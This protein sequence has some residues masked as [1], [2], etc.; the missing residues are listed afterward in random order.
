MTGWLKLNC[1]IQTDSVKIQNVKIDVYPDATIGCIK[2]YLLAEII[3][4]GHQFVM[5]NF[6]D[7]RI[8][9]VREADVYES[10]KRDGTLM[11]CSWSASSECDYDRITQTAQFR[12]SRKASGGDWE[13]SLLICTKSHAEVQEEAQKEQEAQERS[14]KSKT[15]AKGQEMSCGF[16]LSTR[17]EQEE[18]ERRAKEQREHNLRRFESLNL[19]AEL[20]RI[21]K[22]KARRKRVD[23]G[24]PRAWICTKPHAEAKAEPEN[25]RNMQKEEAKNRCEEP[26]TKKQAARRR[27][28]ARK[29]TSKQ[30]EDEQVFRI[31]TPSPCEG[32]RMAPPG[33]LLT[34]DDMV[35]DLLKQCDLLKQSQPDTFTVMQWKD[36]IA[37]KHEDHSYHAAMEEYERIKAMMMNLTKMGFLREAAESDKQRHKLH[38]L[39]NKKIDNSVTAA[40]QSRATGS[41]GVIEEPL[42]AGFVQKMHISQNHNA[43]MRQSGSINE[44]TR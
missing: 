42:P 27:A 14:K 22:E 6:D 30:Q 8:V 29:K 18:Q 21:S 43:T 26:T 12:R 7:L 11:I 31:R 4:S 28:R 13:V 24:K 5:R 17:K 41:R 33:K 2:H 23:F 37:K 25:R 36:H 35:S 32:V 15:E 40:K 34:V 10:D 20:N 1:A 9:L 3:K 44:L 16:D 39:C 38:K 19:G